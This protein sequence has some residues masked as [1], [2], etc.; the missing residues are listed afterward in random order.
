[1]Y[2]NFLRN[3]RNHREAGFHFMDWLSSIK[4]V[5]LPKNVEKYDAEFVELI[6][7]WLLV[8]DKSKRKTCAQC[9]GNPY[10]LSAAKKPQQPSEIM[11][12]EEVIRAHR[13]RPEDDSKS[14]PLYKGTLWKLNTGADPKTPANWL[15]RDMWLAQQG[16]LCY[17]STKENK[18]LVLIDGAKLADA[19]IKPFDD[20]VLVEGKKP[21]FSVKCA[22][23]QE[24]K[25]DLIVLAVNSQEEYEAW[26]ERLKG[27]ARMDIPTMQLG[28]HVAELRK[29]VVSVKNKR[30]KVDE[31]QKDQFAPVFKEKLWKLKAEGDKLKPEDW[32]ERE[33]WISKN[34]SLVYY[35]KKEERDL[36]YY[37][38]ADLLRATY[39]NVPPAESEK[40]FTFLVHLPPVDGVEFAPGEF[41]ANSEELRTKW[42]E[43]FKNVAEKK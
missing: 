26:T 42:I 22:G 25:N 28:G 20:A 24:D 3:S 18:R 40:P 36:V 41:A 13:A 33:M 38:S 6:Q 8:C 23:E 10:I 21:A 2:A 29:F 5:P 7:D 1:M 12:S 43:E 39:S 9:L 14:A 15:K 19:E 30:M 16:S 4:K 17:F 37:T 35:S 27:S 31:E 34:G 11:P 32:F